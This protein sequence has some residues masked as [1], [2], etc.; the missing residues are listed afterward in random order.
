M[1]AASSGRPYE[2]DGW[3]I[4]VK[5][6]PIKQHVAV[7][8]RVV[9]NQIENDD[10]QLIFDILVGILVAMALHPAGSVML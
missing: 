9:K 10:D 7:G 4:I 6:E 2:D 8:S 1:V 3:F 5:P